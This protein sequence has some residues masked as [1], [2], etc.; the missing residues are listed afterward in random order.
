MTQK[1]PRTRAILSRLKFSRKILVAASSVVIAAFTLFT[2]YNDF[3][4]RM[5]IQAKLENYLDEMGGVAASNIANWLAGRLVLLEST[6]QTVARDSSSI[7]VQALVKQPAL[8]SAFAF[9]YLGRSD[10][11]LIIFPSFS[12]Q[13]I[14]IKA[15]LPMLLA[16]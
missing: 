7:E 10:G 9:T 2:L 15:L 1:I 12:I 8:N 11:E 6:A 14:K 5:V 13:G 4:Q 3:L 16:I